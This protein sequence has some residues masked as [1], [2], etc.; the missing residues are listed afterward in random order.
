MI[1]IVDFGS[2]TT[3]LIGRRIRDFGVDVTIIEPER[4]L[5]QAQ[6]LRP[7]G[8]ILS[9]GPASVYARSAPTIDKKVFDLGIP[10]LGICYGWQLTAHLLN[11][12]VKSGKKEYGPTTLKIDDYSDLFYGLPRETRVFE[13]HGDTVY[14]MPK[15]FKVIAKTGSVE[16][17]A[18]REDKR[19]IYG[20]QFHPEMHQ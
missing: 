18:V 7:K 14:K 20:V 4:A 11:G 2:Q 10:I 9:G 8:I 3:H 16:N 12:E 5:R 13:S 1:V 19:K 6:D 15:G 17:A